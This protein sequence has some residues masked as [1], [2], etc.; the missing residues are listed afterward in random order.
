MTFKGK[1]FPYS[2][3]LDSDEEEITAIRVYC[4]NERNETIVLLINNFTPF[5]YLELPFQ[6]QSW[7]VNNSQFVA[8]Y[9]CKQ[10]GKYAPLKTSFLMK[11][12]LYFNHIV[13]KK[14]RLFPYLLMAFSSYSD[15]KS[16][17]YKVHNKNYTIPNLG[18]L[19]F[20]VHEQDANPILQLVC[21]KKISTAGWL[22]FKGKEVTEENKLT[23]CEHEYKVSWRNLSFKGGDNIPCPLVMAMDIEVNSTNP[24][25][26]PDAERPGDKVFQISCIL[27]RH[28]SIEFDKY[29]L[30]LGD[31]EQR[32]TGKDVNIIKFDTESDLLN[33]Y[34]KFVQEKKPNIIC[35]YNILGF[36]IQY[37]IDRANF[38]MI[39]DTFD[40]MGFPKYMHAKQTSIKWSS[41]AYKNQEFQFLDAEG[42]L[43]I[44]LLPLVRRDFKF[45]NYKLK[46]V[47]DNLLGETKDPLTAKGIFE[48]YKRGVLNGDRNAL[49]IVSKYCVQDSMLVC[50]LMDVMQVWVG[51]TEMAKVCNVPIFYLYTQGQ[52]IKVYSQ[53]Y[54]KC[55]YENRVVEKDGYKTGEN[56]C[57]TGA[58]VFNP[59]PDVYDKVVPFDF[60]SLYPTTI[61]AYNIDY[62]T[63]VIDEEVPDRKCHVIE[64]EDHINCEH[65][66]EKRTSKDKVICAA[67]KYRFRK[68]PEGVM[69]NLLKNLLSA[70]T[71]TKKEMKSIKKQIAQETDSEKLKEL[72][73]TL[74]ILDKRQLSYKISANSMYGAMG[75]KRGYLGFMPG[76]MCT[77]AWGRQNI[78]LAAQRLQEEHK[79]RLIYGDTDSCYIQFPEITNAQELWDHCFKG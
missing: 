60:S 40:I 20:K 73:I 37:M 59:I 45:D 71:D 24:T 79:G 13:G 27:T 54:R 53:V 78:K 69:P 30:T 22:A 52:Q 7:D 51:L 49:A 36:D 17:S 15:L 77:T 21:T 38:N 48:C 46:T 76:A 41:S 62:S 18:K 55:M 25:R 33:G 19:H 50:K 43:H 42:M 14:E 9:F 32:I 63:L 23:N 70:R 74:V 65:D 11:K 72:K 29:I 64:W 47:C 68:S 8:N 39:P 4:L 1:A 16:F 10:F 67:R 6:K 58:Y 31:P 3:T 12:K 61:I 75:V 57:Y 35:G 34:A 44:D 5:V 66:T 56:E 2:W 28:G 26:M